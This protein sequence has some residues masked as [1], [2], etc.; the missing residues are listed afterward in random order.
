MQAN[1]VLI[2][3]WVSVSNYPMYLVIISTS[4]Y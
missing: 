3:D 4:F 2:I 1:N